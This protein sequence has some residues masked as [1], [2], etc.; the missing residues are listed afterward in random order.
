MVAATAAVTAE[1]VKKLRRE[2]IMS[3]SPDSKIIIVQKSVGKK[4]NFL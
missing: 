3:F 1:V 2:I 4:L